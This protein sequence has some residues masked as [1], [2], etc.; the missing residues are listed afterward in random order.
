MNT[1]ARALYRALGFTGAYPYHYLE[2]TDLPPFGRAP[3]T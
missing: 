1:P 3:D 2:R